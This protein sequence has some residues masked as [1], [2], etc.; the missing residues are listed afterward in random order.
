[1]K[2]IWVDGVIQTLKDF[3]IPEPRD[4]FYLI[5]LVCIAQNPKDWIGMQVIDEFNT[6]PYAW[7]PHLSWRVFE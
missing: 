6:E 2:E 7:A 5:D 3:L 4:K 1:M